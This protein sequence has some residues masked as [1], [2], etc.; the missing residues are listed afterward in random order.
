MCELLFAFFEAITK[1]DVFLHCQ[2]L[3]VCLLYVETL[4]ALGGKQ[5]MNPISLEQS[6]FSEIRESKSYNRYKE[7]Y[8]VAYFRY[9]NEICS[10]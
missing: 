9:M 4:K 1:D 10:S 3:L 8:R 7:A 6:L 2:E 5:I